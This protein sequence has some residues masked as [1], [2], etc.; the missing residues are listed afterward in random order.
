MASFVNLLLIFRE[1]SLPYLKFIHINIEH[2]HTQSFHVFGCSSV[3]W[4]AYAWHSIMQQSEDNL[5]ECV[6]FFYHAV[7][8]VRCKTWHQMPLPTE[9]SFTS[10]P[11]LYLLLIFIKGN[12]FLFFKNATHTHIVS[13]GH[14]FPQ[15]LTSNNLRSLNNDV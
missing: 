15:L 12:L 5:N 10:V 14:I 2:T 13:L 3:F 11:K 4:G 6:F 9:K 1:I 8:G 7:Y